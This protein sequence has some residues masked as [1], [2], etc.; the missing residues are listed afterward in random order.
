MHHNSSYG[1]FRAR[2][3]EIIAAIKNLLHEKRY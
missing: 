3:G 2:F 1:A